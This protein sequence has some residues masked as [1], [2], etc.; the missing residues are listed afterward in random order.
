[1]HR[2]KIIA[3]VIVILCFVTAGAQA[4]NY[5]SYPPGDLDEILTISKPKTGADITDPKKYC[6]TVTLESYA[7]TDCGLAGLVK[8]TMTMLPTVYQGNIRYSVAMAKCIKVKSAK[9][10]VVTL[11]IQ[12]SVADFL[13]KEVPLGSTFKIYCILLGMT[14]DGPLVLVNEFEVLPKSMAHKVTDCCF[15]SADNSG[16]LL[17]RTAPKPPQEL[18]CRKMLKAAF[19]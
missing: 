14:S 8:M 3:I 13:P 7:E 16:A 9:G 2:A 1:M 17:E 5:K 10:A 18:P 6:L 4:F 12:D 19:S 15:K 11:A